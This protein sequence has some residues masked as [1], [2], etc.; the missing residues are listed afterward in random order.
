[1]RTPCHFITEFVLLIKTPPF[2]EVNLFNRIWFAHGGISKY[3]FLD[4]FS[5][6]FLGQKIFFCH[7]FNFDQADQSWVCNCCQAKKNSLFSK[8][9]IFVNVESDRCLLSMAIANLKKSEDFLTNTTAASKY[10]PRRPRIS[11]NWNPPF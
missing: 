4:H 10:V 7:I 1:M 6:S 3:V 5:S 11:I 8:C 9:M 2:Y